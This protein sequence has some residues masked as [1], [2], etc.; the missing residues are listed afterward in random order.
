MLEL[1]CASFAFYPAHSIQNI[2]I[3]NAEIKDHTNPCD[4]EC[5]WRNASKTERSIKALSIVMLKFL[6]E[7]NLNRSHGR[8]M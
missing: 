5:V 7:T 8:L 3:L 6:I 1:I 2:K 4:L